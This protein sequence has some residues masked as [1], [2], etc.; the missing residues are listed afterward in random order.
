M[1]ATLY[2]PPTL[3]GAVTASKSRTVTVPYSAARPMSGTPYFMRSTTG[4]REEWSLT[5]EFTRWQAQEFDSFLQRVAQ[6]DNAN[7]FWFPLKDERGYSLCEC[8]F[9]EWPRCT[10]NQTWR[11][12]A[13]IVIKQRADIVT[14]DGV[15]VTHD[16][17]YVTYG[18]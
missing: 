4:Q 2:Y 12:T 8:A 7:W 9:T 16:G 18:E 10:D 1:T 6:P 3:R 14:H 17:D 5:F 15:Y 11:Y 13:K